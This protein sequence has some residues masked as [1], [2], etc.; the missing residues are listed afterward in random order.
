MTATMSLSD[1][2]QRVEDVYFRRTPKSR[3][4]H[5]E[6]RA[7]LPNGDTRAGSTF[8]PYPTYVDRGAGSYLHDI[9]GNVLLDFTNN[10]TSL[11]HGHAHPAIVEAI[12]QQAARG[13][14]WAAPNAQQVR[15][16]R[17][18]CERVPSLDRVR[19]CNSGTEA[20]MQV[21]KVARAFTGRDKILK[22][23]GAYH[24]TYDG[25]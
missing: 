10:N 25:V 12:Q 15:L 16:A 7:T 9:D 5:E 4:M 21:I 17:I 14:A 8:P 24:G 3:A 20:N 19:F 13:T 6:A 22:M 11:I 18:L 1:L 23:D 2:R